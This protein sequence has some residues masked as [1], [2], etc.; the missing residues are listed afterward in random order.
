AGTSLTNIPPGCFAGEDQIIILNH[1][2]QKFSNISN[3]G[4]GEFIL[5][6]SS[7]NYEENQTLLYSRLKSWIHFD[8]MAR[9]S[10]LFV[11]LEDS[12]FLHITADHLI[13]KSGYNDSM[14][15]TRA[16]NVRVGD[17]LYVR[18]GDSL[19]KREILE[20]TKQRCAAN[21][22]HGVGGPFTNVSS[23]KPQSPITIGSTHFCCVVTYNIPPTGLMIQP[24]HGS[25]KQLFLFSPGRDEMVTPTPIL[26]S[27][28]TAP[29]PPRMPYN[30]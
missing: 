27:S 12:H 7:P 30:T 26:A 10:F 13:Y 2:F 11:Q 4:N 24:I 8:P 15:L 17:H 16:A 29:A 14:N 20:A 9:V 18:Y 19:R 1:G 22:S 3:K 28:G 5:S 6:L 21:F 23:V 25:R